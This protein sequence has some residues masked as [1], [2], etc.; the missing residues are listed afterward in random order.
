MPTPTRELRRVL[1]T[2]VS[3]LFSA[4]VAARNAL[5]DRGVLKQQRLRRPVISVGNISVGGAGKT[6]FVI[7]LAELL[8][9]ARSCASMCCRAATDARLQE[10]WLSMPAAVPG[11][12]EMSRC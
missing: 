6:P 5:Y 10:C 12:S 7:L 2:P 3:A 11:A 4:V 9:A 1:G 8:R